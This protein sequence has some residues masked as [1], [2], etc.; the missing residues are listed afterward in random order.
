MVTVSS[1]IVP[2]IIT[3]RKLLNLEQ[4]SASQEISPTN[5]YECINLRMGAIYRNISIKFPCYL[6]FPYALALLHVPCHVP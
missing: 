3:S 1:L 6:F 5:I 2:L 4:D